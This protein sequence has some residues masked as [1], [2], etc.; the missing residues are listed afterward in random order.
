MSKFT[1]FLRPL[2]E[3]YILYQ[4]ASDRWNESD[5]YLLLTFDRYCKNKYPEETKLSQ[6]MVDSWC[7]KRETETNNSC[8]S[9]IYPIISFIRYLRKRKKASITE[10]IIPQSEPRTYI[11]HSFT[12]TEL[13]NFFAACDSIPSSPKTEEQLSR[14][15]TIPVYFRLLYSSGIRTYEA[16]MLKCKDVDLINGILNIRYSKGHAQHFIVL[17][18]SMLKLMGQ[19]DIEISKQYP[20][21]TYFFPARNDSFH[22]RAWVQNNFR[23]MWDICNKTYTTAYALRHNYAI[24]NINQ[25][26]GMGFSFD[27][28]LLYLSRSMGHNALESTRY[29]YSLVPGLADIL[30]DRSGDDMII[31]EVE[32]NEDL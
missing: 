16:R 13:K 17:H 12:E 14:R 4:K 28:K 22:R 5:E 20:N 26:I 27:D 19:Y 18:D 21:R 23:A 15:I 24:E 1:S 31:P 3:A 9:R 10:P 29:Y 25:W 8:R 30:E 2:I 11:P 6:E 32:Y 7:R